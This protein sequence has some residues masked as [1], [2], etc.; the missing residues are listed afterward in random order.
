MRGL[1]TEVLRPLGDTK[2]GPA[3]GL[4][5]VLKTNV[6]HDHLVRHIAAGGREVPAGPQ[7]SA[8][9]RLL[10]MLKLHHQLPRRLALEVLHELAYRQVRRARHQQVH[11]VPRHVARQDFDV[12]RFAYFDDQRPQPVAHV[13]V[14]HAF[15][16]LCDPD[17]VIF[18]IKA[19]MGADA[20]ILHPV[21]LP[22]PDNALKVSP[23]GE[24][25]RPIV[26]Q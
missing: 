10:D 17:Q 9:E 6:F 19:A 15:T 14:K 23:E 18:D 13:A 20:I 21:I 3:I 25:F 11:M 24:G 4:A 8:P 1:R 16:V 7:M 22:A 26:R 2:V 5:G 12:V